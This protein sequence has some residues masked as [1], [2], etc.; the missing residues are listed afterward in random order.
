MAEADVGA[1]LQ[2][3]IYWKSGE[4]PPAHLRLLF[5][6]FTPSASRSRAHDTLTRLAALYGQLQAGKVQDLRA[7]APDDPEVNVPDGALRFMFG[8]GARLFDLRLHGPDWLAAGL[9]PAGL[10][11]RLRAG[12]DAPFAALH[13]DAEADPASRQCDVLVQFTATT[14]LAVNRAIVET[15]KAITDDDLPVEIA[16][17]QGGF[18]RDDR[19]SWID[20]HDGIN[21]MRPR[22][23]AVAMEVL[24][25]DDPWMIGG[26]FMAFLKIAVDL[27]VWRQLTRVQQEVIVGRTKLTGCPLRSTEVEGDSVSYKTIDQCPVTGDLPPPL[28]E[29]FRNPPRPAD[30][31][32]RDSH[33]HRSNQ[34]R[35]DP[36]Q[37]SNLRIYRQGYEFLD[38]G[39]GG[40]RLGLNFIGMQRNM[41]AVRNILSTQSWMGGVNFGG[42]AE[43]TG[44]V[45][46]VRL[47]SL[48][49]GGYYA[50]PPAGDPFPGAGLFADQGRD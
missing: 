43:Q 28:P 5:L 14:E 29:P 6:N 47:M 19:R 33:I 18:H 41:S 46:P 37:D 48:L 24:N 34:N 3:G 25:E 9:R 49:A 35:G 1:R 15:I 26:T 38:N 40:P 13:W 22:D 7:L 27:G 42:P 8:Y 44:G 39:P 11:G 2:N 16:G 23:R 21:N 20:F 31:L 32:V 30:H 17:F 12:E 36:V 10:G 4:T 45:K 50:L